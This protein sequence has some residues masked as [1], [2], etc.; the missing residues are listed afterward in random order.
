MYNL[1]LPEEAYK[2]L[3]KL[4]YDKIR[5]AYIDANGKEYKNAEEIKKTLRQEYFGY[6]FDGRID[7][8]YDGMWGSCGKGKICGEMALNGCYDVCVNNNAPNSGHTFV[9]ENGREVVTRHIPIGVVNPNIKYLVIGEGAVID[10]KVLKEE[11]EKY[12]DLLADRPIYV[13]DSAIHVIEENI[14]TE[15]KGNKTG[16]TMKGSGAAL[17]DKIMRKRGLIKTDIIMQELERTG[18]VIFVHSK[19][20]FP[21]IYE[22]IN[23]FSGN[24]D[25]LVECGQ[26]DALGINGSSWP[27]TTSRDC[28]PSEAIKNIHASN[29]SR[30]ITTYSVVRSYPIRIN[31]QSDIGEVYTGDFQGAEEISWEEVCERAGLDAQRIISEEQTTVTKR[32]RRVG[33]FSIA[34]FE[35][36][37]LDTRPDEVI[38]NFARYVNGELEWLDN[39]SAQWIQDRY[40]EI[41]NLMG[42]DEDEI[43]EDEAEEIFR[44]NYAIEQMVAYVKQMEEYFN[45]KFKRKILNITAVGTGAKCG[46]TLYTDDFGFENVSGFEPSNYT[47]FDYANKSNVSPYLD[48]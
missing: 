22:G 25:I 36:M 48:I 9:F 17:V 8:V 1:E 27:N 40:L 47:P 2:K 20:F 3:G 35:E 6:S 13:C 43:D 46:E 32:T 14:Q 19:T 4:Y 45:T 23:G 42:N 10:P 28:G 37:L 38:V 16:S 26:G 41:Y 44:K 12:A 33:E 34:Q 31:N 15:R 24:E 21:S 7:I 5:E 11:I 18:K 30:N 29:F 39:Y